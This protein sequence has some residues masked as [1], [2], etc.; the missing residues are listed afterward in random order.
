MTGSAYTPARC[1]NTFV[2]HND[3][4]WVYGGDTNPGQ[5]ND[6]WQNP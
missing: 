3:K 1:S 2:V 5:L 4:M 6:V